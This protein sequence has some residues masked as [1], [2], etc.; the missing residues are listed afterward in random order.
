MK[1]AVGL[2][3]ESGM[4]N[5]PSPSRLSSPLP[6]MQSVSA[7]VSYSGSRPSLSGANTQAA[8]RVE[9]PMTPN[10]LVKRSFARL[11]SG[12]GTTHATEEKPALSECR[13]RPL[14]LG[15]TCCG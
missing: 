2:Q 7:R 1:L 4:E 6:S 5:S 15:S 10:K 13:K 14:L 11:G 9:T 8:G 3:C 12:G